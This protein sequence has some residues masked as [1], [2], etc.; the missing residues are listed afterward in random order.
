MAAF[1]LTETI[2][3]VDRKPRSIQQWQEISHS[4][5]Q[6]VT[7]MGCQSPVAWVSRSGCP[8]CMHTYMS[9]KVLIHG[10]NIPPNAIVAG[11]DRRKPLYIART[12]WEV[13]E[14]LIHDTSDAHQ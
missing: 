1:N 6:K 3:G 2:Y 11:E 4:N 8:L 7:Q 5:T 12:F 13:G 10:K 9:L 14:S